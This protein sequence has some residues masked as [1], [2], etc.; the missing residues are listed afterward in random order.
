MIQTVSLHQGKHVKNTVEGVVRAHHAL[1]AKVTFLMEK[2][3]ALQEHNEGLTARVAVLEQ[4][5]RCRLREWVGR[6]TVTDGVAVLRSHIAEQEADEPRRSLAKQQQ[7]VHEKRIMEERRL[8][9]AKR[10]AE[11]KKIA[12]EK[13]ITDR[14]TELFKRNTQF[15]L[16]EA[17]R[18]GDCTSLTV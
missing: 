10:I 18:V 6:G 15:P 9:E 14:C 11:E 5:S 4:C 7:L 8:A 13:R 17:S 12:E 2:V 3:Q 16:H 1:L